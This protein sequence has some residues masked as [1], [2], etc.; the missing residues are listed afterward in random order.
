MRDK[1]ERTTLFVKKENER[2]RNH[3]WHLQRKFRSESTGSRLLERE[4]WCW[5]WL[6]SAGPCCNNS[7]TSLEKAN[8]LL[9]IG[10]QS[11]TPRSGILDETSHSDASNFHRN[12]P[13]GRLPVFLLDG[14]R[15]W[16]LA[17]GVSRADGLVN[18]VSHSVQ[19]RQLAS[20]VP[21][22]VFEAPPDLWIKG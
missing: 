20:I 13:E 7:K 17:A 14:W 15:E 2:K 4:A 12:R 16:K 6:S 18:G 11:F 1:R 9:G 19:L 3:F 21:Y 10:L 22:Y 5:E 8:N